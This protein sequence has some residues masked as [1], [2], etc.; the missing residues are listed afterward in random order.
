MASIV[1]VVEWRPVSGG[2]VTYGQ[3]G[4]SSFAGG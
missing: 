2:C 3:D 4:E 1:S